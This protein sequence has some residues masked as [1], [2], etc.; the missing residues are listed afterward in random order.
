MTLQDGD[1]KDRF[2]SRLNR[3][4]EASRVEHEQLLLEIDLKTTEKAA[5]AT[6]AKELQGLL[7]RCGVAVD[8]PWLQNAGER[9]A[10]RVSKRKG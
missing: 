4:F 10:G 7:R 1:N 5:V 2:L 3:E 6:R 8:L 9:R